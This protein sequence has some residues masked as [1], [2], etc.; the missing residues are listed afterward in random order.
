MQEFGTWPEH[1]EFLKKHRNG[2]QVAHS[3]YLVH[4]IALSFPAN[5]FSSPPSLQLHRPPM[6]W[7]MRLSILAEERGEPSPLSCLTSEMTTTHRMWWSKCSILHFMA[8]C[9]KR[10]SH[11]QPLAI[12][13]GWMSS[14]GAFSSMLTMARIALLMSQSCRPMMDTPSK[15]YC[16]VWGLCPR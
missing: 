12:N 8:S 15:I 3:W 16:S 13:S 7:G 11:L 4:S 5:G 6:C 9:S 2:N 1:L 10:F 14:P